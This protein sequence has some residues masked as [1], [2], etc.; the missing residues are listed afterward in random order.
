MMNLKINRE[1]P[2]DHKP[3]TDKYFLRTNQILKNEGLNPNISMKVFTRG[4][5]VVAGLE[6]AVEVIKKYSNL[7]EVGG[8]VWVTKDKTYETKQPLMIIKGPVQSFVELETMYLGVLSH[9]MSEAN[10]FSMSNSSEIEQKFKRLKDIYGDKPITYFGARHYHWSLDK[11]IAGAALKGG[12]VQTSTDRGSSNIGKEGA[13]T[14]PHI[15]T[16]ALA[17]KYGK[18]NA[19]LKTAELFDKNMPESIPRV[20]L[21]DTF[22]KELTDSILVAQY[23]GDRMNLFRI[24]TCGEN[25]GEWGSLYKGEKAKDP[26]YQTGTGVTVE[27]VK[28]LRKNLINKG[29]GGNTGIFLSSGFGNEE[30]AK[31]FV[32]EDKKF[33]KETGYNLFEGVGIGEV[34][35]AIFCTAD[36][37]EI[38]DMPFSKTGREVAGVDYKNMVRRL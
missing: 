30:K 3:F 15:L 29:Y 4:E 26:T 19:T 1:L 27:L 32:E 36:I 28:N 25:I 17:N 38:D 7:E 14:T 11:D 34:S 31:V 35:K 5:G 23:F 2:R 37:F 33:K 20:T 22:N 24:D 12:A 6:D 21:V 9:A 8:E 18:E 13:G 16:L 10:G